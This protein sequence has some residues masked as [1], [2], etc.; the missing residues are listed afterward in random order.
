MKIGVLT[1]GGDVPGLN[2]CIKAIVEGAEKNG[3]STVGIKRG[4]KGL[5]DY[6]PEGDSRKNDA[7]SSTLKAEELRGIENIG[8]TFLHTSR[9]NPVQI[10]G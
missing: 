4:W 8:G 3:W 6:N 5:L 1:S 2:A 10:D 9:F 7:L